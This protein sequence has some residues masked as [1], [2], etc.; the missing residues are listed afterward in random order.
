M[1]KRSS[2][3][4]LL[5]DEKTVNKRQKFCEKKIV[6]DPAKL[7]PSNKEDPIMLTPLHK[8]HIF[9]F[10][11]PNGV[12]VAFNVDSLIDYMLTTGDFSEPETRIPFSDKD[13]REID[14]IVIFI[15]IFYI[16]L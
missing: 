6:V 7:R 8:K 11:R 5:D 2:E 3:Q 14:R 1:I 16:Q 9:K 15:F 4:I 12:C 13:L 10:I